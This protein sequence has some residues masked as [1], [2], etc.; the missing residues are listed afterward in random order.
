[1]RKTTALSAAT[2]GLTVLVSLAGARAVLAQPITVTVNG[3]VLTATLS[4]GSSL[5]VAGTQND[6]SITDGSA[7]FNANAS[8]KPDCTIN[9]GISKEASQVAFQPSGCSGAA[10]TGVRALILSFS[11]TTT[12]PDG[13]VLYTCNLTVT[14]TGMGT[15][16]GVH[17]SDAN[18]NDITPSGTGSS[19]FDIGGGP[20]PT[21]TSAPSGP[22]P[23]TVTVNGSVL[24]A[25]LTAGSSLM[26][27]GTQNDIS[28]TDGSA[29]FN[30]NASNKPDCTI[31]SAL[32]KEA[33]Q[34]AFQPSGC[35]GAACTGV[36]ALILSFSNTSTIPDGSV[37]YTC[38]LTVTGTGTGSVSGVHLSD[39]NGNDITPA[40]TGTSTFTISSG[41]PPTPTT[42]PSGPTPISVSVSGNVLTATL[43]AGGLA[44]AGTQ[45]DI[46]ITDGSASFNAN[47]SGKPDCTINSALGKEA[48]QVAFQPSG[49]SGAACTGVRAL[50][51]S[52]S[53]TTTIPDGSVL[54]TC[55]LTV[56]KAGTGTV[57]GVHLS[58]ASGNDITPAGT[59]T[60]SFAVPF[61]GGI[62]PTTAPTTPVA[63]ST[64][65]RTA[66]TPA[67][68]TRTPTRTATPV[69][70]S[71]GGGAQDEDGC[72]I[73]TRA[74]A[75][76]GWLLLVPAVGL[77]VLRRKRR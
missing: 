77:L 49:C 45:N 29:T 6:I 61:G 19:T 64:P 50:I 27:A 76:A 20:P 48:S 74:N 15:V 68:A 56:T 34:V 36:R 11:D 2:L 26:V 57:S 1:M 63:T 60:S 66:T 9:S 13:S 71:S 25:T 43:T 33:S 30:A 58:D 44:V 46:S 70:T 42:A 51:L 38:N 16:S 23:I 8:N 62:T 37:L 28:I 4:A 7:T 17:L 18:G 54:Y 52:F 73:G 24:T 32:G 40:G 10:C 3:N 75:G 35:S 55:N 67:G 41:P 5:M 22:T 59:G 53:N 31:N 12:I 72:Q 65:V 39:A 21:A 69:N 14:G 47:G